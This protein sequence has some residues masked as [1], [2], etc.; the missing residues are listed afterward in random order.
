MKRRRIDVAAVCLGNMGDAAGARALRL[1][2]SEKDVSAQLAIMA[3][4]LD[5][6]VKSNCL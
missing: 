6:K 1:A 2:R 4:Q 5:M 3:L